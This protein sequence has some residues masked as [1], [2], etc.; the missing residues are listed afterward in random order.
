MIFCR[1]HIKIYFTIYNDI[2]FVFFILMNFDK[3]LVKLDIVWLSKKHIGLKPW[4]GGSIRLWYVE[5]KMF[6]AE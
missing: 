6:D 5:G 2:N 1:Y 3:I 4:D